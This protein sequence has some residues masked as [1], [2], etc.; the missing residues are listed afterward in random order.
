MTVRDPQEWAAALRLKRRG[1]EYVGPCPL[2][3]GDDRF[4]VRKGR[5]GA[6]AVGCRS[7]I[8]EQ[9]DGVRRQRFGEAARAAFGSPDGPNGMRAGPA[10]PRVSGVTGAARASTAPLDAQRRAYA[11]RA[12]QSSERIP[13][14]PAHPARRWLAERCLWWGLLPLPAA[15]RWLPAFP[16]EGWPYGGRPPQTPAVLAAAA[17]PREWEE[18]WPAVP[19]PRAVHAILAGMAGKRTYGPV[20]GC[21]VLI[22]NPDPGSGRLLI[23]EGLADALALASRQPGTVAATLTTPP[24][25]GQVF[26]YA[27]RW[28]EVAV[29]ADDDP[30][31]RSAARQLRALLEAR[32]I[33]ASAITLTA[34]DPAAA[35]AG[36]PLPNLARRRD[37]LQEQALAHLAGS[38]I[39]ERI[40]QAALAVTQAI[41]DGRKPG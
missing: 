22:G 6:A 19:E 21:C 33:A 32:G 35:A 31:G 27:A 29:Y 7:C 30:A 25:Q 3:G 10:R 13:P 40:R 23:A 18:A 38:P 34:K 26:G 41:H 16:A 11:A 1:A 17:A 28:P 14:Y 5:N 12:W 24:H 9:P 2:C 20:R 36:R 39:E 8:D 37:M 15:V 4:H